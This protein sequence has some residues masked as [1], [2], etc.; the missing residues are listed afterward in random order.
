[1]PEALAKA[2]WSRGSGG[3]RRRLP[4]GAP[5]NPPWQP[6]N[7]GVFLDR[8]HGGHGLLRPG[9]EIADRSPPFPLGDHFLIDA[10]ALGQRSQSPSGTSWCSGDAPDEDHDGCGVEEGLGG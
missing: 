6:H 9:R 2:G 8:Q 10:V 4:Q 5:Q 1:M 3:A 7:D